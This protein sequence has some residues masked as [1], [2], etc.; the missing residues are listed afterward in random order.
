VLTKKEIG[1]AM[2]KTG[3]TAIVKLKAIA[4]VEVASRFGDDGR[5]AGIRL[6]DEAGAAVIVDANYFRGILGPGRIFSTWF[7]IEDR[8]GGIA[9]TNG[10][11][12]GHGI[13]LCQYGARYLADRGKTAE[14]IL[15]FYYPKVELVRAY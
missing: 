15:R 12:W 6:V 10:R 3:Y 1:E 11:G 13:G 14:E 7:D 2:K 4:R 9:L 8:G 5:A